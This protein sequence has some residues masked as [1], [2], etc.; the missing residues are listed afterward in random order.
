MEPNTTTSLKIQREE[1]QRIIKAYAYHNYK[2]SVPLAVQGIIF[3]FINQILEHVIRFS[4]ME[5]STSYNL[6]GQP[7]TH[8]NEAESFLYTV[9]SKHVNVYCMHADERKNDKLPRDSQM[10]LISLKVD[11][12]VRKRPLPLGVEEWDDWPPQKHLPFKVIMQIDGGPIKSYERNRRIWRNG[13]VITR[14]RGNDSV[15]EI[16]NKDKFTLYLYMELS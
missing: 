12:G 7:R 1:V 9:L 4:Q 14:I 13:L 15:T 8:I 10:M 6:L 2:G 16:R 11:D 3:R 5:W